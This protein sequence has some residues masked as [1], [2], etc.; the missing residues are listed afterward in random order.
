MEI[1][2]HAQINTVNNLEGRIRTLDL[3]ISNLP[4]GPL[5]LTLNR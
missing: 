5:K 2:K 3:V 1:K 4:Q